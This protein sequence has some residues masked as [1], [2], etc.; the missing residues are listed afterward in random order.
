MPAKDNIINTVEALLSQG[1]NLVDAC[2][3]CIDNNSDPVNLNK[4]KEFYSF[5]CDKFVKAS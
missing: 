1:Y 3:I 4:I 2:R 5:N